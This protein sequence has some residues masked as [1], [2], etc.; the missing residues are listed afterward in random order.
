VQTWC[1]EE[2]QGKH[3]VLQ[4]HTATPAEA[5]SYQV[6][7]QSKRKALGTQAKPTWHRSLCKS[8]GRRGSSLR[9]GDT[10][11]VLYISGDVEGLSAGDGDPLRTKATLRDL[12]KDALDSSRLAKRRKGTGKPID[13]NYGSIRYWMGVARAHRKTKE[14]LQ[15]TKQKEF[16]L[17][18]WP[19]VW[20]KTQVHV[21]E[22]R[23]E[24][25]YYKGFKTRTIDYKTYESK[26]EALTALERTFYLYDHLGDYD[27]IPTIN[28]ENIVRTA[29][30]HSG[31]QIPK[32]FQFGQFTSSQFVV[33]FPPFYK[34]ELCSSINTKLRQLRWIVFEPK[35]NRWV[36]AG[37]TRKEPDSV[38]GLW[39]IDTGCGHDL[40]A[41]SAI[42]QISAHIG[43]SPFPL[44]FVTANGSTK[45]GQDILMR[46]PELRQSVSPYVLESTPSVLSVG[47]RCMKQGYTF[48]WY[49][50]CMPVF[51]SK[52][53]EW[54]TILEVIN[55]IPYL[56]RGNNGIAR[57]DLTLDDYRKTGLKAISDACHKFNRGI[58]DKRL[59]LRNN[60]QT[61]D[62]PNTALPGHVRKVLGYE[63]PEEQEAPDSA[64]P[65]GS[66]TDPPRIIEPPVPPPPAP[67]KDASDDEN[68]DPDELPRGKRLG[69]S[70]EA[71]TP[72]H[73][74]CHK[75]FN[76][77]CASHNH[78]SFCLSTLW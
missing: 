73:M 54:I 50:N 46:L 40:V 49:D 61:N 26:E 70:E 19:I 34:D 47:M 3:G 42:K 62:G 78:F 18:G 28:N 59:A 2:G 14:M 11:Y 74:R 53:G 58:A 48:L 69:K 41:R 72:E 35:I 66:S 33:I 43:R 23:D 44:T 37:V 15:T 75:P 39:L 12:M 31:T 55:D 8:I 51:I 25:P 56:R 67:Y 6:V 32:E 71:L 1:A 36:A 64:E 7:H 45:T 13:T 38:I 63:P 21:F 4:R 27:D 24:R 9:L 29:E 10:S 57:A 22:P 17:L 5:S 76:S 52:D 68:A 60:N 65:S 77:K 20:T 30:Q 16:Y